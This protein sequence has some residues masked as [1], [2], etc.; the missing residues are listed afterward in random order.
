MPKLFRDVVCLWAN[1]DNLELALAFAR[2]FRSCSRTA[3]LG[4]NFFLANGPS[5]VR[6]F[7][8]LGITDVVLDLRLIGSP[9][10]IWQC[11]TGAGSL[12]VKGVSISALAGRTNL[13]HA[14]TAAEACR[15]TSGKVDRPRILVSPL[16]PHIGDAELIDDLGM[17]IRRKEHIKRAAQLAVDVGAD[18]II[19]DYEDM[20]AVRK[21]SR[22]LAQLVFAQKKPKNYAE[23]EAAEVRDL[24]SITDILLTKAAHVILDSQ[25]VSNT[26]AEWAADMLTKE[27]ANN[28]PKLRNK[29]RKLRVRSS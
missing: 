19:V 10:E 4:P 7:H 14:M 8:E 17:R 18:G 3:L 24:P 23:V 26:D 16:P 15:T 21:V 2:D 27:L 5:G 25:L 6:C 9:R 13:E 1:S 12:C 20:H 28:Q 29:P 22:A 11:I